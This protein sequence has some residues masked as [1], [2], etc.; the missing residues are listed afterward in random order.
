MKLDA[1]TNAQR[2]DSTY[3][4]RHPFAQ[5]DLCAPDT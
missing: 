3:V 4:N 2:R 1:S 5:I